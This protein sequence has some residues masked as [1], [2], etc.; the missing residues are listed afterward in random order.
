MTCSKGC[1]VCGMVCVGFMLAGSLIWTAFMVGAWQLVKAVSDSYTLE[2][3]TVVDMG[4]YAGT[5]NG[6]DYTTQCPTYGVCIGYIGAL[7]ILVGQED[8]VV[9]S[10]VDGLYTQTE[11][12]AQ[13][14]IRKRKHIPDWLRARAIWCVLMLNVSM[15]T[16]ALTYLV[17]P[18]SVYRWIAAYRETGCVFPTATGLACT[19]RG[20]TDEQELGLLAWM[21]LNPVSLLTE[22]ATF[23]NATYNIKLHT[24]TI[25]CILARHKW[26]RHAV[27]RHARQVKL[28]EIRRYWFQMNALRVPLERLVFLD[29]TA[30]DMRDSLRKGS[31][32]CV[33]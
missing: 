8:Y 18:R 17:S 20:L 2:T 23:I 24:C 22:A 27:Q 28:S 16:V 30:K 32:V 14:N 31:A 11:A 13:L 5:Y 4:V 19:G 15:A 9:A 33:S 29:E 3:G 26:T 25:S 21:K 6:S 10:N 7:E 1:S 12:T